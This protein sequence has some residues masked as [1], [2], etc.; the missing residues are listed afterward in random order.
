[1]KTSS[2]P[3]ASRKAPARPASNLKARL[4]A[5]FFFATTVSVGY[6]A[7]SESRQI[8]DLQAQLA[9]RAAVVATRTAPRPGPTRPEPAPPAD[10]QAQ[11]GGPA[12]FASLMNNPQ[13]QQFVDARIGQMVDNS[14]ADLFQQLNLNPAD[15]DSLHNLLMQRATAW[16][17]VM[18][19]AANQGLDAAT[20]RDQLRQM[21]TD[22]QSQVDNN[23]HGL[24]G[25]ANYQT[26]QTYNAGIQQNLRAAFGGGLGGGFG[27]GAGAGAGN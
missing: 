21:M 22:A 12:A 5:C 6:V 25:D 24:L 17:D 8:A 14:Y 13:V 20:D 19:T 26:Y 2:A 23:I 3:P 7:W 10:D 15:A 18:T 4:L 9:R 27:A 1:M 11:A 16:R